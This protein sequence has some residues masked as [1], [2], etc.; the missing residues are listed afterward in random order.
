LARCG[1][2]AVEDYD[3]SAGLLD[4][5]RVAQGFVVCRRQ[6]G[7]KIAAAEGAERRHVSSE[8]VDVVLP[9]EHEGIVGEGEHLRAEGVDVGRERDLVAPKGRRRGHGKPRLE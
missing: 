4:E 1:F 3:G 5:Y 9:A 2:L 6:A 8:N 7:K